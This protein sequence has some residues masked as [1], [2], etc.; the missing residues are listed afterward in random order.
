MSKKVSICVLGMGF[1]HSFAQIY[2]LHP[3]VRAVG[4]CDTH[5]GHLEHI[6]RTDG[7]WAGVHLDPREVLEGKTYD[8]VHIC[9]PVTTH[10]PPTLSALA[11]GKHVACA[12]PMATSLEDLERVIVA[13]VRAG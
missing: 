3:D 7:P 13:S 6:S 4:I 11:H 12:V 8:A 10:V 5:P 9:T 2:R 1:G